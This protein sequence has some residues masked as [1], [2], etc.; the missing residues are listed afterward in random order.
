MFDYRVQHVVEM[1]AYVL[2]DREM[3]LYNS[4]ESML[5]WTCDALINV[6]D[7]CGYR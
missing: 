4:N 6:E 1:K 5:C 7:D 3:S 2:C